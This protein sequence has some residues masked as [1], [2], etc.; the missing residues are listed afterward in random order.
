MVQENNLKSISF[1]ILDDDIVIVKV[2]G[3]ANFT[4]AP[5]LKQLVDYLDNKNK[6]LRYIFDMES[7]ITMDSSFL[8]VL[9]SVGIKQQI[10]GDGKAVVVNP[11]QHS[12]DLIETLGLKY[13]LDVRK[14][15]NM[16]DLKDADFQT[17]K[18]KSVSRVEQ[19]SIMIEAHE[20]LININPDNKVE[21]HDLLDYLNQSLEKEE[22]KD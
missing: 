19:L 13:I 16:L 9:A 12:R 21:F 10:N 5:Y 15:I 17:H 6:K 2:T 4:I 3:R 8:G 18:G 14:S 11:N 7:C 1:A 22:Q 20:G